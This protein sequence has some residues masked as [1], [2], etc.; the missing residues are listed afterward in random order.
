MDNR[1]DV[2]YLLSEEG[3]EAIVKTHVDAITKYVNEYLK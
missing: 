2:Q 1:E 3:M